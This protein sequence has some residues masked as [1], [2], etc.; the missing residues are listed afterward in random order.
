MAITLGEIENE[1]KNHK[2]KIAEVLRNAEEVIIAGR[3]NKKAPIYM[4]K[5]R[6]KDPH[7]LYLKTKRKGSKIKSLWDIT[8]IAG[9]RAICLFEEDIPGAFNFLIKEGFPRI[10]RIAECEIY[11]LDEA[12]S[13]SFKNSPL[14]KPHLDS[15]LSPDKIKIARKAS[16]YQSIHFIGHYTHGSQ[17]YS[18]ELQLRTLFQDVWGELEHEIAYKKVIHQ[19]H[20]RQVFN[21]LHQ[22]LGNVGRMLAEFKQ[23]QDRQQAAETF[24][25]N[26]KGPFSFLEYEPELESEI[27]RH[28]PALREAKESYVAFCKENVNKLGK[29]AYSKGAVDLLK[30]FCQ[31]DVE[32]GVNVTL[33][34]DEKLAYWI[35]M[36][37][38]YCSFLQGSF[39]EAMAI[40]E[41]VTKL[42]PNFYVPHFRK[43]EI[44]FLRKEHVLALDSFDNAERTLQGTEGNSLGN[45]I[46][47]SLN[48]YR[49]KIKLALNYWLLGEEY[50]SLSIEQ[51]EAAWSMYPQVQNDLKENEHVTIRNNLCWYYL[52]RFLNTEAASIS[53]NTAELK[54][55]ADEHF[56]YAQQAFNELEK[57]LDSPSVSAEALDTAAWFLYSRYK[58]GRG[59]SPKGDLLKAAEYTQISLTKKMNSSLQAAT[60]A[61]HNLHQQEIAFELQK[62]HVSKS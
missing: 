41:R 47:I 59:D 55:A 35:D 10:G 13:N 15:G 61:L 49:I 60:I 20:I 32:P 53:D 5:W 9:I 51:I 7:S 56:H 8:D 1:I 21:W 4:T 16:K 19:P 25:M 31:L 29:S 40:Y 28:R 44:H 62:L 54:V 11:G 48:K 43:G 39:D 18:F 52:M 22:D 12:S 17:E 23:G 2:S 36:E 42:Y 26:L 33:Y 46:V 27:F 45:R 50:L 6:V 3:D 58:S 38:A 14:W 30:V 57:Y 34:R 37:R 24:Y